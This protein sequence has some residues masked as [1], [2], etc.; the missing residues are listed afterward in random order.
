MSVV[1]INICELWQRSY[2][3]TGRLRKAHC[4]FDVDIAIVQNYTP[5]ARKI[6]TVQNY[7]HTAR[8]LGPKVNR[9]ALAPPYVWRVVIANARLF[10]VSERENR[11]HGVKRHHRGV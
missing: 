9:K 10:D 4:F 1:L 6:L 5:T 7:T 8:N 2:C 3:A 11:T